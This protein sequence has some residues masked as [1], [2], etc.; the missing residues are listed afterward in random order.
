MATRLFDPRSLRWKV[1]ALVALACCAVAAVIGVLV[2]RAADRSNERAGRELA[3]SQLAAA[4][5]EYSLTGNRPDFADLRTAADLPAPLA[6]A[7]ADLRT[8]EAYALWYDVKAPNWYW[9]W[10]AAPVGDDKVIVVRTDMRA[11]VRSLQLLDRSMVQAALAALLVVVP[12][13]ALVAE[14]TNRRLRHGSRTA[15][16]IAGGDLDARIGRQGRARDEITEISVA[17][18]AMAG[19]LQARLATEKRFTADVAHELRTPL[20]GLV[21]AASLLPEGDEA[22][23][24]V[25]TQVLTLRVLVEDLLEVSRLDAGAERARVDEVPLGELVAHAAGQAGQSGQGGGDIRLRLEAPAVVPTDPRR[26][27]RIVT[28]LVANA[29]RHGAPPVEVT[30]T[31]TRITV[32]DHGPGFP[33]DLLA[34]GPQRFRTGAAERG[35]GHGLGLTIAIGHAAVLGAA[36]TFTNAPDGGALATLDLPRPPD[37]TDPRDT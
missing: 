7:V 2:H 10:A 33:A 26:V 35:R 37:P 28:N 36:L 20:M 34:D 25:R 24:L 8:P 9:L 12:V 5:K 23:D 32:R 15:R 14:R 18:D 17:V 27:E 22:A 30:V 16:R 19:A 4:E 11:Q 6:Q 21:T 1:A 13:A 29:H 3:A 31:G